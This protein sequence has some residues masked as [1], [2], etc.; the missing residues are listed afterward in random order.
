[1]TKVTLEDVEKVLPLKSWWATVAV[2]PLVR[3]IIALVV[4]Y[5]SITPNAITITSIFFRVAT[6]LAFAT[7]TQEGYII[8][9]VTYYFAYLLDCIDGAVARLRKMSSEFGRLLDHFG[10]L[11]GDFLILSVLAY[12]NGML[13]TPMIIAMLYMHLADCYISFLSGTICRAGTPRSSSFAPIIYF[14]SYRDWWFN[15][16]FKSFFS[17]PDYTALIFVVFPLINRPAD[18]LHAGF[19]ALLVV[20]IYTIFSS[21][22]SIQTGRQQFP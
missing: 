13:F 6:M 21:F 3:P 9:A 14:N 11:V 1:M 18:G 7:T 8:G 10:D 2:L 15:R 20:S 5:T 12:T 17:F 16:N 19:V 4:N 22:V